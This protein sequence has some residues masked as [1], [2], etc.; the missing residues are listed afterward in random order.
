MRVNMR[1]VGDFFLKRKKKAREPGRGVHLCL[2][3]YEV[4]DSVGRNWRFARVRYSCVYSQ[5][6]VNWDLTEMLR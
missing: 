1:G 4:T 2:T 3:V 5:L 6:R